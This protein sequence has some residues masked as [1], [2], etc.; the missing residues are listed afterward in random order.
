MVLHFA[1]IPLAHRSLRCNVARCDVGNAKEERRSH[2]GS[3]LFKPASEPRLRMTLPFK[4]RCDI[5]SAGET[6]SPASAKDFAWA[7]EPRQG[8]ARLRKRLGRG[9]L[10][11]TD[12]LVVGRPI[13]STKGGRTLSPNSAQRDVASNKGAA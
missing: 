4:E 9:G 10:G 2:R 8:T 6:D 11:F 7:P 12:R 3:P 1:E 5:M 13:W